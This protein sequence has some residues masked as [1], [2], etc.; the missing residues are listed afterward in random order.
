MLRVQ[1]AGHLARGT[2]P[3]SGTGVL[4]GRTHGKENPMP[5]VAFLNGLLV[6]LFFIE[7]VLPRVWPSKFTKSTEADHER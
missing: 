6:L 7:K 1:Y 5:I 2:V 4:S 3:V